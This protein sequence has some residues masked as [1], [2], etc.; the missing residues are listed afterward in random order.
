MA[1]SSE[2]DLSAIA[3]PGFVDIL[4]AVIIMFVFFLMIVA[5]SLFF[6][7][8]TYI[9]KVQSNQDLKRTEAKEINEFIQ[10]QAEFAESEEQE[11]KINEE[12]KSITV[13]FS[14]DAI[15]LLSDV[16]DQII[17]ELEKYKADGQKYTID[18][19]APKPAKT[20]DISSR[21]V[22]VARMFNVRNA[23][24][25]AGFEPSDVAPKLIPGYDIEDSRQWVKIE[26]KPVEE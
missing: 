17:A 18:I 19:L 15:S 11:I 9:S 10:V 26:I 21:K 16:K 1:E 13:F 23:A 2:E 4:S 20:T 7:M 14:V 6:H 3:W 25:V 22:G 8:I 5:V 12:E 24:I